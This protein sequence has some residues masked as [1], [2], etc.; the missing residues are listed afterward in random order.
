MD[1]RLK[2]AAKSGNVVIV[3]GTGV[4]AAISRSKTA[5]WRGLLE[6]GLDRLEGLSTPG[7]IANLR[8]NMEFGF[9][10]GDLPTVLQAA[11]RMRTEFDGVGAAA[12]SKWLAEDIGRLP[13]SDPALG[14]TLRSLPFPILTTNYDTLLAT[15]DRRPVTWQDTEAMQAIMAGTSRDIGHL[16][17][18]WLVPESIILSASDYE[19]LLTAEAAQMLQRSV[20]FLKSIVYVGY[21]AGLQDPN[22]SRLI[23]LHS[24]HFG[25][26]KV[27]HF[28]LCRTGE[29]AD[30]TRIHAGDHIVPVAYGDDYDDL[31]S[32]LKELGSQS[33]TAPITSAGI[34]RDFAGAA[35][36]ELSEQMIGESI[37]AESL[38]AAEKRSL[39]DVVLP[40]VLLPVPHA[41]FIRSRR[42]NSEAKV[43]RC[44]PF[45]DAHTA[46]T[47]VL[48]G[49]EGSG[50]S[51]A[52][53]WM[54]YEAATHLGGAAP[55]TVSFRQ[56]G[57]GSHPL[58]RLV[59]TSARA[60]GWIDKL[61]D[62]MP[63][64]VLVVHDYSPYV[65]KLSERTIVDLTESTAVVRIIT[66]ALGAED[67]VVDRLRTANVAHTLR[68]V[69]R[70]GSRDVEAY[71]KVAAPTNYRAVAGRVI[72]VL[73]QEN[74]PR[75]PLTVGLLISVIVRGTI[76]TANA[77]QTTVLDDYVGALLGRG[78][79][80][81]DAR[82]GMDQSSR[83]A[84]LSMFAKHFVLQNTGGV[85]DAEATR[86][87]E[88]ALER[89][90][91]T[92]SASELIQSLVERRVLRRKEGKVVF[93]RSSFLHLFA[94]KRA[95][96]D[97]GFRA[98][99]LD[100]PLYYSAILSDYAALNRHDIDLVTRLDTLLVQ[101]EWSTDAGGV[102]KEIEQRLQPTEAPTTE[103][104]EEQEEGTEP[105]GEV[106]PVDLLEL[107][108]D[109]DSTPFPTTQHEEL[110][111]G[112]RLMRVLELVS[113]VLRDSDQI[114][115]GNT[116]R[117]VLGNVLRHWGQLMS[118]LEHDPEFMSFVREV[119]ARVH[120]LEVEEGVASEEKDKSEEAD[121]IQEFARLFPAAIAFGGVN[122]TL[123]S[124]RLLVPLAEVV[125]EAKAEERLELTVA[126][127][128]M[129]FAVKEPGWVGQLKDLLADRGN[130]WVI[131]EF[132]LALMI[133]EY[134]RGRVSSSE[135]RSLRDLI[136][137][138][139]ARSYKYRSNS[140]RTHHRDRVAAELDSERRRWRDESEDDDD[141]G[142]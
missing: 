22:F 39:A 69:G 8:A 13:T 129:V 54:A 105:G 103:S 55:I 10:E 133:A 5:T 21:G 61:D 136:L 78:D 117:Q 83:E 48:V 68:Y 38:D 11:D 92:E 110:P 141:L 88:E 47:I 41:D 104:R 99:L 101:D 6:S 109:I 80:H 93:A 72:D 14:E 82:L 87:F 107:T 135:T 71:A 112:L 49:D 50:L 9:D 94:A 86:V 113:A 139:V 122:E 116:K 32:F 97:A 26:G 142:I 84:L 23:A 81:D 17:G 96:Q 90:S 7:L 43:E 79:P 74:L 20:S 51:T 70:L 62:P 19:R 2:N 132:L 140:E 24:E 59:A 95:M 65:N 137:D 125:K 89:L 127:A 37:L 63:P 18:V 77:S 4:S 30:L 131:R 40:P 108:E 29:L 52:A 121:S 106:A 76:L 60:H 36:V 111:L 56:V 120:R 134:V 102:F 58:K 57:A 42:S 123:A 100:N 53:N 118:T 16:H 66:C 75:T 119:G 115:D 1:Q 31:P 44:D 91:W 15:D 98:H 138:I 73:R 35:C 46:D 25:A 27:T 3:A 33:V 28:R 12:L 128:F 130:V 126:S 64:H 124:R 67:D 45:A 34:V 85:S 114:E